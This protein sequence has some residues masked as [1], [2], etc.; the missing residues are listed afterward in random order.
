MQRIGTPDGLFVD[1]DPFNKILGT[2]VRAV[3]LNSMQEE[4]AG[5]IEGLGFTLD[6]TKNNQLLTAIETL[7]EA[8]AGNYLIDTGTANAYA[9]TLNPPVAKIPNGLEIRFRAQHANTAASTLNG[10]PLLRDDG[11]PL[12]PADIEQNAIITATYD[13]AANAFLVN[14]IVLSQLGA[15]AQLGLGNGFQNSGGNLTLKLPDGSLRLTTAGLQC[16]EPITPLS[17]TVN[18]AAANHF[19][20]FVG[21]GAL[22]LPKATTLWNGFCVSVNAQGGA[23]TLAPNAADAVNGNAAGQPYTL[24]QGVSALFVTDGAG[25]WWPL[26]Q[27]APPNLSP[28]P[29]YINGPATLAP[30]RYLIDTS[31]GGFAVTL[32]AGVAAG[33]GWEFIDGSGTWSPNNLTINTNGMT[34]TPPGASAAQTGPVTCNVAGEDFILWYN[35]STLKVF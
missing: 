20:N 34:I 33:Q 1:G 28:F 18:I 22:N 31:A 9:V 14:S 29:Q 16:N 12:Q 4:V 19:A 15:L 2:I 3:W 25:N 35:G 23:V 30:G 17:G 5:V 13:T 32:A 6:P 11:A 21:A 27:T 10:V 24:T 26:Y 7:I 8:R